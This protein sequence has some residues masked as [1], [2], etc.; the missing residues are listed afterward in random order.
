MPGM[1]MPSLPCGALMSTDALAKI[2]S[3]YRV[4]EVEFLFLKKYNGKMI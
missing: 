4:Y 1:R 2:T 3:L